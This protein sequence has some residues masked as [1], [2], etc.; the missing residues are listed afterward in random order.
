[1]IKTVKEYLKYLWG[2]RDKAVVYNG[3]NENRILIF[4]LKLIN[5]LNFYF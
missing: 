3:G 5:N 4:K 2:K 1:M